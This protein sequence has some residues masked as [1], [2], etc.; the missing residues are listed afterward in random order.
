MLALSAYY[1]VGQFFRGFFAKITPEDRLQVQQLLSVAEYTLFCRMPTD[2]QRHG[3]NVYQTLLEVGKD[4]PEL[5]VAALLHD[6]GKVAADESGVKLNL[7]LR[8]PLVLTEAT[9]AELIP[10]LASSRPE[11]G[12][13]YTL[14]VHLEHPQI[15]AK[16]AEEAGASQ[17]VC[18]L[19][20]A[21]QAQ[22]AKPD[23]RMAQSSRLTALL[24]DLQWADGQN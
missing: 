9:W 17:A 12:W 21:H 5:A 23:V 10:R 22:D 20:A 11:D 14:Y 2:A 18:W 15:G 19:I 16:W 3:L 7:W 1:R 4:D 8:I 24:A 13:R 6:V